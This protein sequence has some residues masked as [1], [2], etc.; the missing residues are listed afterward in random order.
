MS[1][2]YEVSTALRDEIQRVHLEMDSTKDL[3][4]FL[5]SKKPVDQE[6][7]DYYNKKYQEAYK[8]FEE[9]KSQLEKKL[10]LS[11]CTWSLDYQTCMLTVDE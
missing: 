1:K 7:L 6:A 9:F 5:W 2:Q 4:S 10:S 3:I 8:E 11:N